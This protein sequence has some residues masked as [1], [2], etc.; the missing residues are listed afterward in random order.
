MLSNA[1][2]CGLPPINRSA[3]L[4]SFEHAKRL[5]PKAASFL[6]AYRSTV[7]HNKRTEVVRR[8]LFDTSSKLSCALL[9]SCQQRLRAKSVGAH[10]E[11]RSTINQT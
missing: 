5:P 10:E 3:L 2:V 7:G 6:A 11:Q 4:R 8:L 9:A 1:I